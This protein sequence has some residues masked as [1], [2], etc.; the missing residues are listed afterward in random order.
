[1][2]NGQV[3]WSLCNPAGACGGNGAFPSIDFAPNAPG[4]QVKI[5][6][7][8]PNHLGITFA[9]GQSAMSVQPGVICPQGTIWNSGVP[10]QLTGFS[11]STDGTYVQF[12]DANS[13]SGAQ[14]FTYKLNFVNSNNQA[15][16]SIDPI[17]RNGGTTRPPAFAASDFLSDAAI[18]FFVALIVSL[19]VSWVVARNVSRSRP[20]E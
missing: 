5:S 13:N 9:A 3:S 16:T 1:M 11:R 12:F 7:N 2:Q 4:A 20:G 14:T 17:I 10:A 15:V 19:I 6:I 8:D 18:A